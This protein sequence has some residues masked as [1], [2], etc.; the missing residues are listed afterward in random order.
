MSNAASKRDKSKLKSKGSGAEDEE[1]PKDGDEGYGG[2][3]ENSDAGWR[4]G[5]ATRINRSMYYMTTFL[6]IMGQSI[7][8]IVMLAYIFGAFNWEIFPVMIIRTV[9]YGIDWFY[10]TVIWFWLVGTYSYDNWKGGKKWPPTV[11][12]WFGK[13]ATPS[14]F[15][16]LCAYY[17][18]KT[19]N[20]ITITVVWWAYIT[21]TSIN[22]VKLSNAENPPVTPMPT[23]SGFFSFYQ[24]AI[25]SV[26]IGFMEV[27]YG[28]VFCIDLQHSTRPPVI[29]T[30]EESDEEKKSLVTA[31]ERARAGSAGG[32]GK[33]RTPSQSA[34]TYLEI[35]VSRNTLNVGWGIRIAYNIGNVLLYVPA[36]VEFLIMYS[37]GFP[38]D[39]RM[40]LWV[41]FSFNAIRFAGWLISVISFYWI[42]GSSN[43]RNA[44]LDPGNKE[45]I[46]SGRELYYKIVFGQ[47]FWIINIIINWLFYGFYLMQQGSDH[48]D[49]HSYPKFDRNPDIPAAPYQQI[50]A[51][52]AFNAQ[53]AMNAASIFL[54]VITAMPVASVTD[55]IARSIPD[56]F[57][58]KKG[59]VYSLERNVAVGV[60]Q[61][62]RN[63]GLIAA[64]AITGLGILILY[65]FHL[66]ACAGSPW[67]AT[68]FEQYAAAI[69]V[70]GFILAL[71]LCVA[72]YFER[73]RIAGS[74]QAIKAPAA[75]KQKIADDAEFVNATW[76]LLAYTT[77]VISLLFMVLLIVS[78]WIYYGQF[79]SQLHA[80]NVGRLLTQPSSLP[81]LPFTYYWPFFN[82]NMVLYILAGPVVV[83]TDYCSN[84]TCKVLYEVDRD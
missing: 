29:F 18:I 83:L 56:A 52:Y 32:K 17:T 76:T 49:M 25:I 58:S 15:K 20:F 45:R 55:W 53:T 64:V 13:Y 72:V 9:V 16:R 19:F 46:P 68:I 63:A 24:L 51:W 78:Y 71:A 62:Q 7:F 1:E 80:A 3:E 66:S 48:V 8:A 31:G 61:R 60:E 39:L 37:L 14:T 81:L 44:L 28:S 26:F 50:P 34:L 6:T 21:H 65:S 47:I 69:T 4:K 10:Y 67:L 43:Y 73:T 75:E 79:A 5:V 2:Q 36:T 59:D 12:E 77:I 30:P 33:G 42:G 11:K 70:I 27:T 84:L 57:I 38:F 74:V 82:T 41:T 40:Q 54:L 22:G 35:P 23:Q